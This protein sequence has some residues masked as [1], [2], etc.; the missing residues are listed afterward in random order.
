MKH[1]IIHTTGILI[2][3]LVAAGTTNLPA[4]T[5]TYEIQKLNEMI[6]MNETNQPDS[7]IPAQ[8]L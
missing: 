1:Q 6:E 7:I 3:L 8:E 2:W 5:I 4:A